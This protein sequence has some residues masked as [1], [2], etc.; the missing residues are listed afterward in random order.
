MF[1]TPA[2]HG[3]PELKARVL[4]QIAA[5]VEADELVK[6]QYWQG[7]K[8]C[9]VGCLAHADR[10]PHARCVEMFGGSEMVYRLI[11]VIFER[12]PNGEAKAWP[13]RVMG[14][15]EPGQDLSRVGWKFLH[16]L[17]TG[18]AVDPGIADPLV[19]AEAA[20]CAEI[21]VPL[22]EGRL[23]DKNAAV[24]AAAAADV[25]HADAYAYADVAH[26]A[27]V[28][29]ANAAYAVAAAA[30][31][32]ADAAD[33]TAVTYAHVRLMADKLIELIEKDYSQ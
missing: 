3:K 8:G 14:A 19:S 18:K 17:L 1:D 23:V 29:T 16:W 28:A 33:A 12:L 7:G 11:D 32:A 20:R 24:A 21:L 13:A 26:A 25:A 5:H 27:A 22:T 31:Y 2:Y 4:A 30:S 9:A 15:I 6:G 10:K